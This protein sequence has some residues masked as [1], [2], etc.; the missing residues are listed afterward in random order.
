MAQPPAK[1]SIPILHR[2]GCDRRSRQRVRTHGLSLRCCF[3]RRQQRA[4][5][6]RPRSKPNKG[7]KG[8]QGAA[9]VSTRI[10][11]SFPLPGPRSHVAYNASSAAGARHK[12]QGRPAPTGRPPGCT[13]SKEEAGPH[14]PSS[15]QL[16]CFARAP[17]ALTLHRRP[18]PPWRPGMRPHAIDKGLGRTDRGVSLETSGGVVKSARAKSRTGH[19]HLDLK[20]SVLE[21]IID[22]SSPL[23]LLPPLPPSQGRREGQ[24]HS[25]STRQRA[26]RRVAAGTVDFVGL[27][28]AGRRS[29]S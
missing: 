21:I 5:R 22:R 29:V 13:T 18:T 4:K 6:G 3:A 2:P 19:A 26:A 8:Q 20:A 24:G 12:G 11:P 27:D 1:P 17:P 23:L 10:H 9:S 14:S 15:V 16:P 7:V 28:G 25:D